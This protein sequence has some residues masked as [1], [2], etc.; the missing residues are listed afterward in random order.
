ML[1]HPIAHSGANRERVRRHASSPSKV[2]ISSTR[3][4][5]ESRS[6][7][8]GRE[9]RVRQAAI[10]EVRVQ[11]LEGDLHAVHVVG[12]DDD[13]R[14]ALLGRAL[15]P[16]RRWGRRRGS[17]A[18]RP[19]TRT[20]CPR[21]RPCRARRRRGRAG[22]AHPSRA[23][24]AAT[25][26]GARTGTSSRRSPSPSDSAHSRSL[27]RKSPTNRAIPSIPESANAW[28]NGRGS[29]R[30]K[31]LPA[32]VIVKR[33]SGVY[34]RPSKSSKSLPFATTRTTPRA[35]RPRTSSAIASETH[36]TASARRATSRATCSLA[37]CRAR[38][39]VESDRRCWL[40]TIGSRRSASQRVPVAFCTAAPTKCT[41]PGG[42]VVMTASIPS[43][44]AILIAAG[45]A[46]RFHVT[47]ASGTSRR[48]AVTCA[49]RSA[50]SNPSAARSSSAGLRARG[51]EVASAMDPRLRGNAELGVPVHP[52]RVVRREHM[53]LD[54]ER[55]KVLRELQRALDAAAARGRE[56][57]R[58]EEHLH[59]GE[60]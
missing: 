27:E 10:D 50:R 19:G 5:R 18:A 35:P 15:R 58:D 53:G 48:L 32:W 38:V 60:A 59:A 21:A 51:S 13:S 17:G 25:P 12:R 31:K 6:R 33:G 47:L 22:G 4:R 26:R 2:A 39:A 46:V 16:H 52:L 7:I 29:R 36:E 55:G 11:H 44:R 23:A 45:I 9:L 1:E 54:S 40:A 43:R 8:G 37:A 56:V 24:A 28:R 3:A 20:P 30:P 34:S 57:H 49:C 14:D 41:E 42:E